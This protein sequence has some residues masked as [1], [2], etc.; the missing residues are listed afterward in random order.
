MVLFSRLTLLVQRGEASSYLKY[1]LTTE[2]TILFKDNFMRDPD[3]PSLLKVLSPVNCA[4]VIKTKYVIDGGF[5][6]HRVRWNVK[7]TYQEVFS[8]YL[9]YVEKHYGKSVIV[10]DGYSPS[11]KDHEHQRRSLK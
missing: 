9:A 3:K 6:L 5:L 7:D 1:E 11:T 10:L 8:R 4:S 2:P